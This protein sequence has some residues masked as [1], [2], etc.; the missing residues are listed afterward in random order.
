V[1]RSDGV[2]CLYSIF[3]TTTSPGLC[4]DLFCLGEVGNT[5]PRLS[6]TPPQ[7]G[8]ETMQEILKQVQ[9]DTIRNQDDTDETRILASTRGEDE[10]KS[11][12]GVRILEILKQVQD[13]TIRN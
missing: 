1:A 13:D 12:G 10:T 5:P 8:G 6:G 11:R 2:V 3:S 9:D 7:Q 4:L